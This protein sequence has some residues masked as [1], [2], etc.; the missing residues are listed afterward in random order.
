[1][2]GWPEV[3]PS[4]HPLFKHAARGYAVDKQVLLAMLTVIVATTMTAIGACHGITKVS[5]LPPLTPH[6][7]TLSTLRESAARGFAVDR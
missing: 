2:Y 7:L 4:H 6:T 1:M 3:S 5:P